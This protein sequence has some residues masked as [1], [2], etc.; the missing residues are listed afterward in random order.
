[1]PESAANVALGDP[2]LDPDLRARIAAASEVVPTVL[3][4]AA[5]LRHD[6]DS[7]PQTY[8]LGLYGSMI[9]QFSACILLAQFGEPTTIPIILRSMYEACRRCPGCGFS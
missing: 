7:M 3:S 8:A 2:N 5:R 4:A 1:V 6:P 9:E